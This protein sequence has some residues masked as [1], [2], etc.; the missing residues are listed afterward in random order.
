MSKI[1]KKSKNYQTYVS[2][3]EIF[4]VCEPRY[5]FQNSNTSKQAGSWI[6]ISKEKLIQDSDENQL[7]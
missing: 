6:K 7:K 3:T 1:D 4:V 2:G 5:H